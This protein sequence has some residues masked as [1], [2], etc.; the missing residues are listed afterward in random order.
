[1]S[2]ANN[3]IVEKIDKCIL[4]DRM[5][6]YEMHIL[7]EIVDKEDVEALHYFCNKGLNINVR[8]NV[9]NPVLHIKVNVSVD[10][11]NEMVELGY[12]F[13]AM[14]TKGETLLLVLA[15]KQMNTP[16]QIR[17]ME[18]GVNPYSKDFGS[19][20]C[21]SYAIDTEISKTIE[22]Y[23]Q[24]NPEA[25]L[26]VEILMADMGP[27]LVLKKLQS[28]IY[29]VGG[30]KKIMDYINDP[31]YY[32]I[33]YDLQVALCYLN[34]TEEANGI[35]KMFLSELNGRFIEKMGPSFVMAASFLEKDYATLFEYIDYLL[36]NPNTRK[37]HYENALFQGYFFA[38]ILE[39]NPLEKKYRLRIKTRINQNGFTG[40]IKDAVLSKDEHARLIS[41]EYLETMRNNFISVQSSEMD[42]LQ[43]MYYLSRKDFVTAE[44]RFR[45]NI[46]YSL[47]NS[48]VHFKEYPASLLL[49]QYLLEN[50]RGV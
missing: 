34:R 7:Q 11:F 22:F 44:L 50:Q 40:L 24:F 46:D 1:M 3:T 48:I 20:N 36:G 21:F 41:E 9:N 10:F 26:P 45:R 33:I 29:N 37:S 18:L 6:K 32:K 39:D 15:R 47:K 27:E 23:S 28:T 19:R 4:S 30:M 14:N 31:A 25:D 35:I 43:G 2:S 42:F 13:F 8:S 5:D 16:M 12:N 17:L 38:V 49:S